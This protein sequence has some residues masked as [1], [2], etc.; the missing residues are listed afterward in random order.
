MKQPGL[1]DIDYRLES[2]SKFGDPLE[3]L[4]EVVDFELFRE[5]LEQGLDFSERP[6]GG[7]SPYD[8]VLI[9]KILLLQTLYTL[10]DDQTEYQI[11]GY[12][13]K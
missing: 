13:Q 6:K 12:A 7:R 9:F 3:K 1:F 2:L 10:S 5:E 8:A 4:K 11:K